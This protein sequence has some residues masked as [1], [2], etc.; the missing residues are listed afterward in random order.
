[1]IILTDFN[2]KSSKG[3]LFDQ[4]KLL[5]PVPYWIEIKEDKDKRSNRQNRYFHGVMLPIL[6]EHTGYTTNEIK[7]LL[8]G[9]FLTYT[10]ELKGLEFELIKSTSD[11]DTKEME[12]FL[13]KCRMFSAMELDCQVPLPGEMLEI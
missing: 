8:K 2:C 3:K 10:I 11:L 9:M 13:E 12:E 1:M 6:S 4:L 5:K 7:A